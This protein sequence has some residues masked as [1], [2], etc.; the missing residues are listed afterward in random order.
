[1]KSPPTAPPASARK[2][3]EPEAQRRRTLLD[4]L[5][6]KIYARIKMP[7]KSKK[8][9]GTRKYH[10]NWGGRRAGAGK[11][12]G[13]NAGP[14]HTPRPSFSH[15]A[16]YV[17]LKAD[18]NL[19]SRRCFQALVD[20]FA[21]AKARK[22]AQLCFFSVEG[23]TLHLV[24]EADNADALG[25][26]MQGLGVRMARALNKALGRSGSIFVE[27]YRGTVLQAAADAQRA[28]AA[29]VEHAA[30]EGARFSSQGYTGTNPALADLV[31]A[32]TTALLRRAR[33]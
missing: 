9:S 15:S 18:T 30:G 10:P 3:S 29:I 19:R 8:K 24:I 1:M 23:A 7:P 6:R 5:L 32:P 33:A 16:V 17:T 26:W 12:P 14:T 31:A 25:T 21:A 28:M 20:A 13:P 27:R 11:K 2:T 4:T 22:G